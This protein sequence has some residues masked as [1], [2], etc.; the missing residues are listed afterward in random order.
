ME[1]SILYY[2]TNV[3]GVPKPTAFIKTVRSVA[4]KCNKDKV[5]SDGAIRLPMHSFLLMFNSN[6]WPNYC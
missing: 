1:T 2:H 3:T 5:T 4:A 6:M